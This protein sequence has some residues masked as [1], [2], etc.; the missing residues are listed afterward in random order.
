M[1]I[2]A[3]L[4]VLLF[5]AVYF[6]E[7][8]RL[9]KWMYSAIGGMGVGFLVLLLAPG[10]K[11]RGAFM[12]ETEVYQG[13]SALISRGLKVSKAIDKHLFV[14]IAII[15]LLGTYFY[16]KKYRINEFR[17]VA[18]FAFASF[19]T[20]GVLILTPEPMPRAYF[21]ANIY[22]MIAAVQMIQKI[23]EEDMILISLKT[24]GILAAT[25]GMMFVYIE[26]GANLA[27]ILREVNEREAY[28]LEQTA[29]GNYDLTLPMLRPQFES[30]YSFMYESDVSDE[31][32]FWI[33]E[34][35]C[36]H[37]GLNSI[38]AVSREEWDA[39]REEQ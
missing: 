3:I 7:N 31:E 27:R 9:E 28:I 23:R 14:Y 15:I 18:I 12:K 6:W 4:I 11:I 1:V 17:E 32:D 33:N 10:N 2:S 20:A 25:V 24:G 26:E 37:Y 22:M 29:Q 13:V 34:V 19:A 36:M 35:F 8:Q 39:Y 16:Y 38:K 30:K 5:T 21:G